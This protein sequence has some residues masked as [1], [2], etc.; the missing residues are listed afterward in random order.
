MN[1]LLLGNASFDDGSTPARFASISYRACALLFDIMD[2]LANN[3]SR[4]I[5]AHHT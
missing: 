4:L 3:E 2:R 1:S 5:L